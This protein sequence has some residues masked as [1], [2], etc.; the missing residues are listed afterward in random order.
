[1]EKLWRVVVVTGVQGVGKS[2]L[3]NLYLL[4][5]CHDPVY[6]YLKNEVARNPACVDGKFMKSFRHEKLVALDLL[7]AKKSPVR[8]IAVAT[9]GDS[10]TCIKKAFE[11]AETTE[12]RVLVCSFRYDEF[13]CTLTKISGTKFSSSIFKR[14]ESLDKMVRKMLQ[15]KQI[16]SF[17]VSRFGQYKV[18]V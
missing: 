11:F 1:M 16:P 8:R 7:N 18:E 14:V 13:S 17:D 4:R 5:I 12:A 10:Q 15:A 3:L 9:A 2:T 6:R